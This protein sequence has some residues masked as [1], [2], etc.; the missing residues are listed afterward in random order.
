MTVAVVELLV[1]DNAYPEENRLHVAWVNPEFVIS[2]ELDWTNDCVVTVAER[3]SK[4]TEGLFCDTVEHDTHKHRCDRTS[5]VA[6]LRAMGAP[7]N[8]QGLRTD[9]HQDSY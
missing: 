5:A 7:Y 9:G 2:V 8:A 6:L 1:G 4:K 3:V